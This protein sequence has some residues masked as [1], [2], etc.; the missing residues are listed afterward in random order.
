M[1]NHKD[2]NKICDILNN[3][4]LDKIDDNIIKKQTKKLSII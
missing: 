3:L 2:Y 4:E 1:L